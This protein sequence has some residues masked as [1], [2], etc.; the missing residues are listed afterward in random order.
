CILCGDHFGNMD[1]PWRHHLR[2]VYQDSG[3]VRVPGEGLWKPPDPIRVPTNPGAKWDTMGED[4]IR[5]QR[6]PCWPRYMFELHEI[7]WQRLMAHFDPEG[8]SPCDL[9][10]ALMKLPFPTNPSIYFGQDAPP[11]ETTP[12]EQLLQSERQQPGCN[13]ELQ[14]MI[15]RNCNVT[16]CFRC[17]PLEI[18][19]AVGALLPTPDV[20][21]TRLAS[22]AWSVLFHNP[23]FWRTRFEIN[24][25]RGFLDY[26]LM[27][28]RRI[29]WRLLYHS[30]CRLRCGRSFDLT[31][32]LWETRRWV[33]DAILSKPESPLMEFGG[34]ALQ[35]YHNTSWP[36]RYS[37]TV[38]IPPDLVGIGIS[39][40]LERGSETADIKGL[41]SIRA[42]GPSVLLGPKVPGARLMRED[43][44]ELRSLHRDGSTMACWD[45][46]AMYRY[47]GI[48][49]LLG[50]R[51]LRGAFFHREL[52]GGVTAIQLL[53]S[54][55][56]SVSVGYGGCG[57]E[58]G[59]YFNMDTVIELVVTFDVSGWP[60]FVGTLVYSNTNTLTA[61]SPQ[62][63][64]SGRS[65]L[66]WRSDGRAPSTSLSVCLVQCRESD[67]DRC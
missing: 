24:G 28:D 60:L 44:P 52:P 53:R 36:G 51:L 61:P 2:V 37:R 45:L 63:G 23:T 10:D 67:C 58:E 56:L 49:V 8:V 17:L 11:Y 3:T 5:L 55:D 66:W 25:E 65:R 26:L 64:T 48:H 33:R 13:P 54:N 9:Y 7:C 27:E 21:N 20:L 62:V 16:D 19:E 47:P 40:C 46:E 4:Y 57:R 12:L 38:E 1:D 31:I 42:N 15:A 43:E 14:R 34:R 18:I 50:A 39:A 32:R 35:H 59:Y 22:R 29:D 6:W 41:G 30:T